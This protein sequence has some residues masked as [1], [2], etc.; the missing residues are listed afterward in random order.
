VQNSAGVN[1]TPILN[2]MTSAVP[3][4]PIPPGRRNSAPSFWYSSAL[5]SQRCSAAAV[6]DR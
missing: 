2:G 1:L 4:R 6:R 5:S 3:G